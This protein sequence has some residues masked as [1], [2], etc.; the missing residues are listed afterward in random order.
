MAAAV[1][2]IPT[3][4]TGIALPD[5]TVLYPALYLRWAGHRVAID[6]APPPGLW[7]GADLRVM[8]VD[9]ALA[10]DE[11]ELMVRTSARA[12]QPWARSSGIPARR[13][14]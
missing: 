14:G 9:G 2:K 1:W 11:R 7:S 4:W 12:A 10:E 5:R 6:R 13:G 3:R 8:A